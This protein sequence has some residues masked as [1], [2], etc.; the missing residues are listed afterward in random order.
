MRIGR[1]A[2]P[3][4]LVLVAAALAFLLIPAVDAR[5]AADTV[6]LNRYDSNA[7]PTF[8]LNER[9]YTETGDGT[10]RGFSITDYMDGP[11]FLTAFERFGGEDVLGFPVSRPFAGND[12]LFYQITQRA[13]LQWFPLDR[14]A[15]LANLYQIM[16]EA[17]LDD[18]LFGWSIPRP[19]QDGAVGYEEAKSIR[20]A[21]M[22]EQALRTAFLQN[23]L[24]PGDE[25]IS[26]ELY[27]LPMSRPE[28]FGPFITQR[29]QRMA[30]QFWVKDVPGGQ[31]VGEV[32][33][34]NGGDILKEQLYAGTTIA[35]PHLAGEIDIAGVEGSIAPAYTIDEALPDGYN[36]NDVKI[37]RAIKMLEP[38][39]AAREGLEAARVLQTSID[40]KKLPN[41]VLG[42]FSSSNVIVLSNQLQNQDIRALGVVLLHELVHLADW[43]ADRLGPDFDSCVR[44][45]SRAITA[46]AT[47]WGNLVGSEGKHPALTRLER[48]ENVRL[49]LLQ[50]VGGTILDHAEDLYEEI[51]AA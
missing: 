40:F 39:G 46:E 33:P 34:I 29:F 36:I 38:L 5:Q 49:D 41:Q 23:P 24:V 37:L 27:G 26:I 9:F 4:Q 42:S 3:L 19:L 11:Q 51:C 6:A 28:D 1:F 18:V 48:L 10:G 35:N 16:E 43:R 25:S 14:T 30:F 2:K 21:W 32:V 15:R 8:G 31:P 47:A 7:V 17:G 22:T 13:L 20:L 12:G 50:G 44:A 45:E